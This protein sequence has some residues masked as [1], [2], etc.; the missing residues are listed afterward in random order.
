LPIV[1]QTMPNSNITHTTMMVIVTS[2]SS[3][4]K[5]DFPVRKSAGY[6]NAKPN[7]SQGVTI[8]YK[9]AILEGK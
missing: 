6:Y 7:F 9:T 3:L 5:I 1:I 4:S 8:C 2:F